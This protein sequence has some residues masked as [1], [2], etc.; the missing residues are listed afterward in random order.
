M[1]TQFEYDT[2]TGLYIGEC[3]GYIRPVLA[4]VEPGQTSVL[5]CFHKPEY[6]ERFR[7]TLK[8]LIG[9]YRTIQ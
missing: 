5:A 9:H 7:S 2:N 1:G 3:P 6:Q 8:K 4:I